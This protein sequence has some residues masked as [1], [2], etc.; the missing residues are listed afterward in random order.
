MQL[1]Q[2]VNTGIYKIEH[3]E[4]GKVYIGSAVNI[5][6]RWAEHRS[7]LKRNVHANSKLQNAWNKYGED[8]FNFSLIISCEKK[9]LLMYEQRTLNV[10]R[11][12]ENGYNIC[13]T[14]GSQ[15]GLKRSDEIKK[16]QSESRKG[17][18]HSDETKRKIREAQLGEKNHRFGKKATKEHR[19]NQSEAQ[20]GKKMPP[21]T[22]EQRLNY[23]LA[24]IGTKHSEES[25][26]KMRVS[27]TGRKMSEETKRKISES[28]KGFIRSEESRRKQSESKLSKI[29]K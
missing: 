27:Q 3:I 15:L 28:R 26:E 2:K 20:R 8:A 25:K 12:Y 24:K 7:E 4:S 14:A 21:R 19:R 9:D 16:A 18:K 13:V 22:E 5:R 11:P 6:K 1:Q 17:R 23:S 29:S 10:L